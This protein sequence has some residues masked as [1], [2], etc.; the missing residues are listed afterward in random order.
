MTGQD[1]IRCRARQDQ[2]YGRK[3]R[4]NG[5]GNAIDIAGHRAAGQVERHDGLQ[6]TVEDGRAEQTTRQG[7]GQGTAVG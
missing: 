5:K 1:R 3:L 7:K 2:G 6:N 4:D